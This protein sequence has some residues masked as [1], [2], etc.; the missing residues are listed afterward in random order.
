MGTGT[1]ERA[2]KVRWGVAQEIAI[3]WLL[4]IPSSALVA[5][6]LY[7]IFSHFFR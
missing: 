7:W 5:A 6:G 3:A 1:A 4:T 2:N